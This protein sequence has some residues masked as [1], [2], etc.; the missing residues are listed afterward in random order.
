VSS[1]LQLICIPHAGA[2][3]SAYR[4]WA[5]ALLPDVGIHVVQLAGREARIRETPLDDITAVIADLWS[6]VKA[7]ID[8]PFALF[9][10]SFGGLLAFEL[11][12][13]I[14]RRTGR[15]PVRLF[16]SASAAP[17]ARH[18]HSR[19]ADLP[20]EEFLAEVAARYGGMPSAILQDADFLA[21][22]L[23][24]LRADFRML[25]Q[26]RVSLRSVLMC[27]ISAFA[28]AADAVVPASRLYGW[29]DHTAGD[30]SLDIVD[31]N[32]FYLQSQRLA[33]ANRIKGRLTLDRIPHRE[34]FANPSRETVEVQR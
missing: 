10:H 11:A 1:K 8:A 2:G 26:Y 22:I 13:E 28:G 9:G 12:H 15:E 29:A 7:D 23:P 3:A 30:F 34:Q 33:L 6:A 5:D 17:Q 16:V 25:E 31:G 21:L 18:V 24:A 14:R 32:H 4:L 27:P 20:D 19:L